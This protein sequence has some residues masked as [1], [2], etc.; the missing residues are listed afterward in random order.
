MRDLD[1]LKLQLFVL[2][3]TD[4]ISFPLFNFRFLRYNKQQVSTHVYVF[5]VALAL[6]V[7]HNKQYNTGSWVLKG[8][9]R[10]C[11]THSGTKKTHDWSVEEHADLF[12]TT[13][14]VKTQ[15]VVRIR[16][17]RCGDI[18]LATSLRR[19]LPH[20]SEVALTLVFMDNCITQLT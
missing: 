18:E 20:E 13:H 12:H 8:H 11:T 17:Q 10:T 15:Q 1:I 9:S 16:C 19:C 4:T 3:N 6:S 14:K 7:V 2:H 5:P